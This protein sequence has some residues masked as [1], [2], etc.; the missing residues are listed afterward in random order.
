MVFDLLLDGS[1]TCSLATLGFGSL[2]A[3]ARPGLAHLKL[4]NGIT[5]FSLLCFP[6]PVAPFC[7]SPDKIADSCSLH[8]R[9]GSLCSHQATNESALAEFCKT[10]SQSLFSVS[11]ATPLIF[12]TRTKTVRPT[13]TFR[14]SLS[15]GGEEQGSLKVP[16]LGYNKIMPISAPS[17]KKA[18]RGREGIDAIINAQRTYQTVPS[19]GK[20]VVQ[21]PSDD[22]T[23][24]YKFGRKL[25]PVDEADQAAGKLKTMKG[26]EVLGSL[27]IED[28]GNG[29]AEPGKC[30]PTDRRIFHPQIPRHFFHGQT[31]YL[32]A[33]ASD[34]AGCLQ[35]S[36]LCQALSDEQSCFLARLVTADDR[37]P[38][39]GA[40][41]AAGDLQD[42]K[43]RLYF[44]QLPFAQDVK[45]YS[46][47]DIFKVIQD[48]S[49]RITR[50]RH[51][52]DTR[53]AS[54]ENVDAAMDA[55]IEKMD[56]M[57]RGPADEEA[58]KSS[59]V[60]S[61]AYHRTWQ[62][63]AARAMNPRAPVPEMDPRIAGQLEPM[64]EVLEDA[65]EAFDELKNVFKAPER[66]FK[67][68]RVKAELAQYLAPREEGPTYERDE[69][70]LR[71]L[72]TGSQP[73]QTQEPLGDR[74]ADPT[75]MQ[76]L[77]LYTDKISRST[78]VADFRAMLKN[79]EAD[80]VVD[81][82]RQMSQ[83]ITDFVRNGREESLRTALECLAALR[84]AVIEEDEVAPY[85]AFVEML[86]RTAIASLS[87]HTRAFWP[88]WKEA[89]EAAGGKL[90]PVG[91]D[92]HRDGWPAERVQEFFEEE[93]MLVSES[94][95]PTKSPAAPKV[96]EQPAK[97]ARSRSPSPSI[98][99]SKG[100][101]SQR[102]HISDSEE[103]AEPAKKRTVSS[104]KATATKSSASATAA[105]KSPHKSKTQSQT[106]RTGSQS[107]TQRSGSAGSRKKSFFDESDEEDDE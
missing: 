1:V 85:Q 73:S 89:N 20:D 30:C 39:I 77:G 13:A 51:A 68:K 10:H 53:T 90:G 74:P 11:A 95:P 60:F 55:W 103:D 63:V 104:A 27:M 101:G 64:D 100:K 3:L 94:Q 52:W 44:V 22:V 92:E 50:K 45:H 25:V 33:D 102:I 21:V 14:G 57:N 31:V 9:W 59:K 37:S 69:A 17:A 19:E 56:L 107:H 47:I 76:A 28:V 12:R 105:A 43:Q 58:Y 26:C 40:L 86:K 96:V 34:T 67:A 78:A 83:V 79:R 87:S 106:Q 4:W 81:A 88:L 42:R 15:I 70:E 75:G 38:K 93:L 98:I 46:F 48:P 6:H 2:Y 61:P 82:V 5:G 8:A 66:I 54:T 72:R 35:F 97:R 71:G 23:R 62:C 29:F 80:L 7:W 91:K 65:I 18:R 49:E 84:Q 32:Q 24:A 99:K 36:A 16:S 41:L